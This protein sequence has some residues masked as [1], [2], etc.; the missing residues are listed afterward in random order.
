MLLLPIAWVYLAYIG[1]GEKMPD[2]TFNLKT[3]ETS[4]KHSHNIR[5]LSVPVLDLF[6]RI[7]RQRHE[8]LQPVG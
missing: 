8:P 6:K 2:V 5:A 7:Q 4:L 3:G 1:I